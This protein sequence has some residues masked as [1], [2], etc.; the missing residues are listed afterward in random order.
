MGRRYPTKEP[1]MKIKKTKKTT[2]KLELNTE[3]LLKLQDLSTVNGGFTDG[4]IVVTKKEVG[5]AGSWV[6]CCPP[7]PK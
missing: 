6:F 3:T 4:D 2:G 5:A 7:P 1:A